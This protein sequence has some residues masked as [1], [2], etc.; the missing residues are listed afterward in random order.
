MHRNPYKGTSEKL[1][2]VFLVVG[3]LFESIFL[4]DPFNYFTSRD[5]H[6]E[7]GDV[8][9]ECSDGDEVSGST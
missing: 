5:P 9:S 7:L 6:P 4:L 1:S 8:V 3:T 2:Y